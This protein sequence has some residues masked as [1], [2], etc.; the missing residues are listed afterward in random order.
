MNPIW[1]DNVY[2]QC[3]KYNTKFFFKQWGGK[4]KCAC[5]NEWG[6]RLYKGKTW[7]DMP[8]VIIPQTPTTASSTMES[9]F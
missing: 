3:Q 5:H 1:V 9:F 8:S 4:T 2:N 7:D 6:C